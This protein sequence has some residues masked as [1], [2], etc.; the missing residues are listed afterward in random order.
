MINHWD[1]RRPRL[2]VRSLAQART[3]AIPV[4]YSRPLFTIL[5]L[6]ING[7]LLEVA[8]ERE[9]WSIPASAY[10][11]MDGIVCSA[12][13]VIIQSNEQVRRNVESK[14]ALPNRPTIFYQ[15]DHLDPWYRYNAIDYLR[16]RYL[17][18][19]EM[20]H[21]L[22][23][24]VDGLKFQANDEWGKPVPRPEIDLLRN[25][26]DGHPFPGDPYGGKW[27]QEFWK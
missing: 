10:T 14:L 8:L 19:I 13:N 4:A 1:R 9:R 22:V 2:H 5:P 20:F 16:P 24:R 25:A 3:P 11:H 17:R 23:G 12:W 18:N 6:C 21:E 26:L 27:F 7:Y 15:V